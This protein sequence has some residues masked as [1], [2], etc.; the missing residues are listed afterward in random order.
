MIVLHINHPN[1][2]DDQLIAK[3]K[4]LKDA[5]ATLLNQSV[6]LAS[7]NDDIQ[8]LSKLN[9]DLFGAGILP[10]YLHI[11]DKVQ[12]RRTLTSIFMTL[13]GYIGSCLKP[14]QVIWFLNWF[15]SDQTIHLRHRLIFISIQIK[16]EI[17]DKK[18][19]QS[20]KIW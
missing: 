2:I 18:C 16:N 13:L 12:G 5:G 14:Y 15:K 19:L 8:T 10:Y 1:E 20:I 4:Q 17:N 3:T 6:L 9:Q 7:I 11:L